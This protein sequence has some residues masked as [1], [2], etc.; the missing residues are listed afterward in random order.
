MHSD[1]IA[2]AYS[3]VHESIGCDSCRQVPIIG[4]R[5]RDRRH[6][7]YDL[8]HPC[9]LALPEQSYDDWQVV[10]PLS[11]HIEVLSDAKKKFLFKGEDLFVDIFISNLTLVNLD[12]LTLQ[13]VGGTLPFA[14]EEASYQLD[15][16]FGQIQ[17]IRLGGVVLARP[18]TYKAALQ[19]TSDLYQEQIGELIELIFV[20][21]AKSMW[22]RLAKW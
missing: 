6:V 15:M 5:Y 21:S 19:L 20:I 18:G 4:L 2:L 22:K 8:C 7:N 3:G 14:F 1:Y 12:R 9:Y 16:S 17:V 13:C 10:P 11:L